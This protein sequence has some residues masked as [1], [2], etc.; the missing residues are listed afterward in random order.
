MDIN[1]IEYFQ[2]WYISKC[3]GVWEHSYGFTLDTIDNPGW[4]VI[5]DGE[6]NR[7]PITVKIPSAADFDDNDNW[8]VIDAND[9]KF[10]GHCSPQN[11]P[12]VLQYAK[13]WIEK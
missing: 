4:R 5:L 10:E 6:S 9:N 2:H 3:D 11:L 8:I 1:F 13:E 7:R 12:I